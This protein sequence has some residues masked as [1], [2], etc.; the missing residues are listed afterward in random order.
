M[1]KQPPTKQRTQPLVMSTELYDAYEAKGRL[2]HCSAEEEMLTRL[3]TCREHTSPTALYLPDD[4]RQELERIAGR[5]LKSAKDVVEWAR[6]L[7]ALSVAGTQVA[8]G[9]QL[10][11]RLEGRRFGKPMPEFVAGTTVNLLEEFV[12]MR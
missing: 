3:T 11:K 4:A 8:L 9:E 2:H 7:A 6:N 10:L 5:Q 1:A 12:G